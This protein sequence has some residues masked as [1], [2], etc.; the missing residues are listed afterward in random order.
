MKQLLRTTFYI[1]VYIISIASC[2]AQSTTSTAISAYKNKDYKKA[3]VEFKKVLNQYKQV[4]TPM[5]DTISYIYQQLQYS[6]INSFNIDSTIIIL[7][8]AE[9]YFLSKNALQKYI[10][11]KMAHAEVIYMFYNIDQTKA[12]YE[13]ILNHEAIQDPEKLRCHLRLANLN[14][15]KSNKNGAYNHIN[16]ALNLAYEINDTS[17]LGNIF[18]IYGTIEYAFGKKQDAINYYLEAIPY[19]KSDSK[20]LIRTGVYRKIGNV[21]ETLKNYEK[22]QAYAIKSLEIAKAHN[23]LREIAFANTLLGNTY[24]YE[25]NLDK[26]ISSFEST[27]PFYTKR[28]M[29]DFLIKT[30]CSLADIYVTKGDFKQSK[31]YLN[32]ASDH[33]ENAASHSHKI[34]YYNTSTNYYTTVKDAQNAEENLKQLQLLIHNSGTN[35]DRLAFLYTKSKFERKFGKYKLALNTVDAYNKLKD[36]LY[37]IKQSEI[38]HDLEGKYK[39]QEQ[40]KEIALL[41]TENELKASRLSKQKLTIYGGLI[42]LL[43]FGL[44]LAFIFRLYRKVELQNT[45][46]KTAL[47]E[48]DTLLREIHHRVKNNLQVVSS[49]LALQS[50]YVLDDVALSALKEGQDRVQSM[51][52]IHQDLYENEDMTGVNTHIYLEQ[53][54]ENLFDSYNIDEENISYK[55]DVDEIILDIDT[56]IPLGLIINELVSNALKHGFKNNQMGEVFVSLKELR[57]KLYLEVSDDGVGVDNINE[58]K[59]KSFGFELIQAFAKKLKADMKITSEKGLKIK[60]TLSNYKKAS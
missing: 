15:G 27:I 28:K 40:D 30:Y 39:R 47:N 22:A 48:K 4:E 45:L 21:F 57:N 17:I 46:I 50:K 8:E 37:Y 52:L 44:L 9:D 34:R 26:A 56:M 55:I 11:F 29:P 49:L 2:V 33:I 16:K 38:I 54:V 18:D 59:N 5:L 19:L 1:G 13:E 10:S 20:N 53:L 24:Y 3:I 35:N 43:I 7:E 12:L 58:I 41:N 23:Y 36:S 60:M 51:A 14:H 42:A 32:L 6:Y 25:N 31:S